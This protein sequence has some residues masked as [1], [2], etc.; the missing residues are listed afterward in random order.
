VRRGR[1][2]TPRGCEPR[3]DDADAPAARRAQPLGY[4][5]VTM[6][7]KPMPSGLVSVV[8]TQ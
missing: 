1:D 5:S 4:S 6:K 7:R 3:A 8:S 2:P